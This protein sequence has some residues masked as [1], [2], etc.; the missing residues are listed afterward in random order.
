MLDDIERY[1]DVTFVVGPDPGRHFPAIKSF[2]AQTSP[3]FDRMLFR[4][5]SGPAFLEQT[6]SNLEVRIAD[7][8][9]EAFEQL[10]RWVHG[11]PPVLTCLNALAVAQAAHK[12]EVDELQA[13]VEFWLDEVF[14]EPGLILELYDVA[15]STPWPGFL[16]QF[17]YAVRA[18]SQQLLE[19]AGFEKLSEKALTHLLQ[20]GHFGVDEEMLYKRCIVWAQ[21]RAGGAGN[22]LD[23][24]RQ[25]IP[26]IRFPLLNAT[27]FAKEVVPLRLLDE[28]AALAVIC[29][30]V[31]GDPCEGFDS[32]KRGASDKLLPVGSTSR[33]CLALADDGFSVAW[34][35]AGVDMSRSSTWIRGTGTALDG[36]HR[37]DVFF[38]RPAGLQSEKS[39]ERIGVTET[40]SHG[41]EQRITLNTGCK[42]FSLRTGQRRR[43]SPLARLSQGRDQAD[44]HLEKKRLH[45]DRNML[46]SRHF[47]LSVVLDFDRNRIH[48]EYNGQAIPGAVVQDFQTTSGFHLCLDLP[49]GGRATLC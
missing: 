48:W 22:W 1:S 9:A 16:E 25:L 26:H 39:L 36:L 32:A 37:W 31:T 42:H 45:V 38:H 34:M 19:S 27:F 41:R 21:S 40:P 11:L 44:R 24:M 30:I 12:Y 33:N 14:D 18:S 20:D 47:C 28:A 17:A 10:Q 29:S 7:V 43:L 2:F 4:D 49:V 8:S 23:A 15:A 5:R 13:K 6:S 35:G 3:V 46:A